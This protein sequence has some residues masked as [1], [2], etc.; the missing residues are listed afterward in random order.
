MIKHCFACKRVKPIAGFWRDASRHD[1]LSPKCVDCC[2][3]RYRAAAAASRRA[4]RVPTLIARELRK[5]GLK[6]CPG[7]KE[8][9]ALSSFYSSGHS[10]SGRASHCIVCAGLLWR[11]RPSVER[12]RS[13]QKRRRKLRDKHLMRRFGV[14]LEWYEKKLRK[15]G[16]RC[17][18]CGDPPRGRGLAVDHDHRS[19]KV[20]G[21]LCTRCNPAAGY[22]RDS[23]QIARK[24]A[25]YLELH[26]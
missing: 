26:S 4:E 8:V 1:G 2:V 11:A 13:Y 3:S 14:T 19:G 16:G 12:Q 24:L 23:P 15:Q 21:L 22:V 7:C 10:N 6:R 25:A 20:R 5:A 18:I 17:A 9:K